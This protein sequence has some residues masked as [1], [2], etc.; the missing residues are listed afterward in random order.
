M[1]RNPSPDLDEFRNKEYK[2]SRKRELFGS[3]IIWGSSIS[4]HEQQNSPYD[5]KVLTSHFS[6]SKINHQGYCVLEEKEIVEH[7]KR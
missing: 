5:G 7:F 1:L 3:G 4:L 6:E 2:T